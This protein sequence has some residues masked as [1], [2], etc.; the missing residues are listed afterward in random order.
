[1]TYLIDQLEY[2][3]QSSS[4]TDKSPSTELKSILDE[5]LKVARAVEAVAK[6][7]KGAEVPVKAN[8][9]VVKGG[10]RIL[11]MSCSEYQHS[12]LNLARFLG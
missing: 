4:L 12:V 1:M 8:S 7:N 2:S 3:R 10:K 9:D 6:A 11:K 5:G